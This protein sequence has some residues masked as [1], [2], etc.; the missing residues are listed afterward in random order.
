MIKTKFHTAESIAKNTW[1][2]SESGMVNCYLLTGDTGALLIDT[3]C[4]LGDLSEVVKRITGLSVTVVL[5]H[6]HPDHDY[7]C[8]SKEPQDAKA[9]LQRKE[10]CTP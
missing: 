8:Q 6:M 7:R 4:G 10:K 3:G 9:V 5:T 2:I 1:R